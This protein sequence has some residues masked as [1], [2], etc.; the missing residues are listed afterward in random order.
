[1]L[2]S[3]ALPA[4]ACPAGGSLSEEVE[5]YAK[6]IGA[7]TDKLQTLRNHQKVKKWTKVGQG[8]WGRSSRASLGLILRPEE[9]PGCEQR[10]GPV[11][12]MLGAC[13]RV[14]GL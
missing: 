13:C 14:K 5:A 1:M 11:P 12:S 4:R 8:R 6:Q 7:K 10:F 9:C 3:T 2:W